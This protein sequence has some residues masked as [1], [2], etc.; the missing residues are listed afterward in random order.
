M[1]PTEKNL[2]MWLVDTRHRR[3]RNRNASRIAESSAS[4]RW[5]DNAEDMSWQY[6]IDATIRIHTIVGEISDGTE[7]T[8]INSSPPLV[9]M[10]RTCLSTSSVFIAV[11]FSKTTWKWSCAQVP[12]AQHLL[13]HHIFQ[14]TL[15]QN[16]NRVCT[17]LASQFTNILPISLMGRFHGI[18]WQ[19]FSSTSFFVQA[20]RHRSLLPWRWQS[21]VRAAGSPGRALVWGVTLRIW[22]WG[23]TTNQ[24][25]PPWSLIK[26]EVCTADQRHRRTSSTDMYGEWHRNINDGFINACRSAPHHR[27]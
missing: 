25:R 9:G 13:P 23:T 17:A 15:F 2:L 6:M 1:I 27:K 20:D 19:Y 18:I 26:F 4:S 11:L 10:R 3:C 22:L 8:A 7:R 5:H 14:V 16:G 21:V 24:A 12:S